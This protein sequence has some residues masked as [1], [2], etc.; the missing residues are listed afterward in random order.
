VYARVE[1]E[2]ADQLAWRE[3]R[4][5]SPVEAIKV[6]A[7]CTLTPGTLI[8]RKTSGQAS[9]CL[10]ISASRAPISAS[11]KSTWRRQPSSV[12]RSSAGS[13]SVA[14]Q[15]RPPVPKASRFVSAR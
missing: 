8:N 9:A 1:A 2:L 14:S 6:A 7:V 12:R 13:S 15:R 5:M 10:A 11:R 4:R 3:K